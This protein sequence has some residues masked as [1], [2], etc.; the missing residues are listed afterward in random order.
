ME[1]RE[2]AVGECR[3]EWDLEKRENWEVCEIKIEGIGRQ[4]RGIVGRLAG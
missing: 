4:G 2:I 1:K 3:G